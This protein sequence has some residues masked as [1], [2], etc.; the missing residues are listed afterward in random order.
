[1]RIS[2][3]IIAGGCSKVGAQA[4][5]LPAQT[6][7]GALLWNAGH[8]QPFSLPPILQLCSQHA[9][10]L[11]GT[12]KDKACQHAPPPRRAA[13]GAELARLKLGSFPAALPW[14]PWLSQLCHTGSE[15][16]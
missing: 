2:T 3:G 10:H 8:K 12:A 13:L 1:M 9:S 16:P 11:A 5:N 15:G 6:N 7:C 14:P 4:Q